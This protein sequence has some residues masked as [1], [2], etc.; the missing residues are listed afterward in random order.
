MERWCFQ[1][2]YL[3]VQTL[4]R[5]TLRKEKTNQLVVTFH[6]Y[7]IIIGNLKTCLLVKIQVTQL[8]MV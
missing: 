1:L 6:R 3:R 7:N 8:P 5:H 4:L 2:V